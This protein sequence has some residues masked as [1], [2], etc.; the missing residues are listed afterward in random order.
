MIGS[1]RLIF[2]LTFFAMLVQSLV[3]FNDE[4][5]ELMAVPFMLILAGAGV[6][7]VGKDLSVEHADLQVNIF[8]WAFSVR[9]WMG[10]ILYGWN[11]KD[12]FGDEDAS[13]Y[14]FAWRMAENWW[15]NG[16]EGFAA[17]LVQVFFERQNIGQSLVWAIPTFFAGDESRMIVSVVNCFAGAMLAVV[18]FKMAHRV[19]GYE[20]ASI[21]A[22][23]VIFWPSNILLSAST[24]KEMLVITLEWA[25]LYLLIRDPRGLTVKDSLL[26]VPLLLLVFISRFYALYLLAAAVL[27]RFVA[28]RGDHLFRNIAFGSIM[29]ISLLIFLNAGGAITRDFERIERMSTI[30]DDWR[31]SVAQ[32][33]GSG[34]EI[35]SEYESAGVAIPVATVYFFFAPFPW[36][37]FSGSARNG[38]GAIE[39]IAII[40]IVLLGFPAVR[41]VFKDRFVEMAPVFVF[42]VL[43][44]GMHIWGLSNIGLAWRHKQTIMPLLFILVAVGITQ[45]R[46]GL[47]LITG[48]VRKGQAKQRFSPIN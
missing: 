16:F 5:A 9:L 11:L 15:I 29:V 23:L 10:M 28:R 38:F 32:T 41:I 47:D 17:D 25:I 44:A 3:F 43:Y 4:A 6:F 13:G 36:E 35:Y 27:F 34:I 2:I 7:F 18:I 46:A 1:G 45:R 40:V 19:F 24:A 39:N 48:R 30:V 31:V 33:T 22:V 8:L 42:C 21:A 14:V 20:V 26:S 12:L 37:V